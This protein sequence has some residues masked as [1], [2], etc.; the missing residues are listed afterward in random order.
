MLSKTEL[1]A[2]AEKYEAKASRAYQNYQET[3]ITRYDRERR[4]AE[5]LASAMRMA[6]NAEGNYSKLVNLRGSMPMLAS[7]AQV[8]LK[9][10]EDK[11][12]SAMEKVLKDLVAL[13]VME[14]LVTDDELR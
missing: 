13:A 9:E 14:G 2:L 3:G 12:V 11:R 7:K 1:E 6:A 4:N 8:A 10:Q 5:D